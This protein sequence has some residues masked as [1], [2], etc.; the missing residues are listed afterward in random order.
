[1]KKPS[2]NRRKTDKTENWSWNSCLVFLG[3]PRRAVPRTIPR[4]RPWRSS[5]TPPSARATSRCTISA[6]CAAAPR[7]TGSCWPARACRGTKMETRRRK[8]T[9]WCWTGWS[10]ATWMGASCRGVLCLRSFIPMGKMCLRSLR[11]WSCRVRRRRTWTRGRRPFCGPASTR[12]RWRRRRTA[13]TKMW[14][15]YVH[16][17][18]HLSA[19]FCVYLSTFVC[20]YL[21]LFVYICL[22]LFVSIFLHLSGYVCVYLSTFVCQCLCLFFYIFLAMFVSICLH[23]SGY[24]CVYFSTFV[25]LCLCLFFY[26]CLA[27][28]VSMFSVLWRCLTTVHVYGSS[29]QQCLFLQ[30]ERHEDHSAQDP[31]LERQV[32]TI[33]GLVDSYM[34]IITKTVKDLIPKCVMHLLMNEVWKNKPKKNTPKNNESNLT[35]GRCFSPCRRKITSTQSSW[36]SC[37]RA[38][39]P[40]ASWRRAG[41]R[42]SVARRPSACTTPAR[43]L[44]ASSATSPCPPRRPPCRPGQGRL[45]SRRRGSKR[46]RVQKLMKILTGK[47]LPK[48]RTRS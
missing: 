13:P 47:S 5:A 18:L 26:I 31:N 6:S 43:K 7:S 24:V 48:E 32:E 42:R 8:S 39:T 19:N 20:L 40:T 21:C 2:K 27:M 29:G 28:F 12:R 16:G 38:P 41:M 22:P 46:G 4:R 45:A 44:S 33:R 10:C 1:M 34:K 17:K 14:V 25:C 3:R 37:T 35:F 9:C 11:C 36:R 15:Q 23:L 30:G